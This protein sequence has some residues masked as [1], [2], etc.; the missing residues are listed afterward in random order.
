[1]RS[2]R[3]GLAAALAMGAI[4]APTAIAAPSEQAVVTS[5]RPVNRPSNRA[6]RTAWFGTPAQIRSRGKPAKPKRHRN[7]LHLSKRVRRKHRRA[8]K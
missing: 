7:R 1:M 4:A 5:A 8:G 6:Q 3:Y 2:Y